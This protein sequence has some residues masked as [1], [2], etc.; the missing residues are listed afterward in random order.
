MND[1]DTVLKNRLRRRADG[2]LLRRAL[3]EREHGRIDA[4]VDAVRRVV[5]ERG[6]RRARRWDRDAGVDITGLGAV[7]IDNEEVEPR[8][9][10]VHRAAGFDRDFI[11]DERMNVVGEA[12]RRP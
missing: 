9:D 11:R 4:A 1:L 10:E 7:V 3:K 12:G 2:T 8:D 5:D 6:H